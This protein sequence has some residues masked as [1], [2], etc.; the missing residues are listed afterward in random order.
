[1]DTNAKRPKDDP[2]A[3]AN[4]LW[5]SFLALRTPEDVQAALD[6][7]R[8]LGPD[9][10]SLAHAHLLLTIA[11]ELRLLRREA[12]RELHLLARL[13]Q[14]VTGIEAVLDDA[15]ERTSGATTAEPSGTVEPMDSPGEV[16]PDTEE[17]A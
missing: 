5:G 16:E 3:L 6:R 15:V 1:M 11:A 17:V 7:W 8:Q 13:E 4:R 9:G 10:Q 12:G 2:F 14:G